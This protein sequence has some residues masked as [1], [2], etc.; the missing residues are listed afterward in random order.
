ML[1]QHPKAKNIKLISG[2]FN[3][4]KTIL[5][6]KDIDTVI[7][8]SALQWASNLNNAFKNCSTIA[9]FGAFFI[10]TSN[11]FKDLH[12]FLNVKSP[13]HNE[14]KIKKAFLKSYK[15]IKIEKFTFFLEFNNSL[16]MLRYIKK[17]GVTGGGYN[18]SYRD[19]KRVIDYYPSRTLEF[20]TLLLVGNDENRR[21]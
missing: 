7:S 4:N 16:D 2:D 8:S 12:S 14:D 20:E 3:E 15:P 1:K 9:P 17:S 19:L 11:T 13:I 18:L 6:F 10:F 21:V 5:Q